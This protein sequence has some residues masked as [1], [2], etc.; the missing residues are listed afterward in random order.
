M[1]SAELVTMA[2]DLMPAAFALAVAAVLVW[3]AADW[4]V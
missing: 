4:M 2:R 3:L 1:P